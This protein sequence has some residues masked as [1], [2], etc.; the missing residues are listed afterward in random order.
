MLITRT[1]IKTGEKE[2]KLDSK[3]ISGLSFRH[4]RMKMRLL[5]FDDQ[6]QLRLTNEL[7]PHHLPQYQYAILSHTWGDSDT[8]EVTYK[9]L[10]EGNTKEKAAGFRKILFCGKRAQ[11]DGL[12]Y[13]WVDT[14]C[15][16][17][18]NL[19]E[20]T[21]AINSMF[22]WYQNATKCYVFL[23]DLSIPEHSSDSSSSYSQAGLGIDFRK[24]RWF[25]R[26][27]TL[28]EL[29]AP[30]RV[31]FFS[32]HG[33][34]IG[35]KIS[36]LHDIQQVTGIPCSVLQGES[37]DEYTISD[38]I[39][40]ATN[41]NTTRDEDRAY[42]L[43]GICNVYMPLLYG[44]GHDSALK[45]LKYESA[46]SSDS[47]GALRLHVAFPYYIK[48]AKSF[49]KLISI[50]IGYLNRNSFYAVISLVTITLLAVA[51]SSSKDWTSVAVKP[52]RWLRSWSIIGWQ[53][54]SK[55]TIIFSQMATLSYGVLSWTR[56]LLPQMNW[57]ID[58]TRIISPIRYVAETN[59]KQKLHSMY[60]SSGARS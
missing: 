19:S 32:Q 8:D 36:L 46:K 47:D 45:R 5:S 10:I 22:S 51:L 27:W 52:F 54:L 53:R 29:I 30:Q 50:S 23:S 56:S 55:H 9:D 18:S 58:S 11:Q 34:L 31:E 48:R 1:A 40:W 35:D 28:Q 59:L 41:R 7:L 38:R 26:G 6:G 25:T 37:L 2:N 16:D 42:S 3:L 43:L 4:Y 57:A 60:N 13:F 44:E 49:Q 24:S 39:S 21:E 17:K 33:V 15:I 20:L 12:K 14:C